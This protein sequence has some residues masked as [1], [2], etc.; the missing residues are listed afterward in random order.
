MDIYEYIYMIR[1]P[2]AKRLLATQ[3]T[4]KDQLF[5]VRFVDVQVQ[6][7]TPRTTP[8]ELLLLRSR[9]PTQEDRQHLNFAFGGYTQALK[10]LVISIN[11]P[12]NNFEKTK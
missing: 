3:N 7:T 4:P 12:F 2:I 10:I 6:V 9:L 11:K 8:T 5:H 1:R